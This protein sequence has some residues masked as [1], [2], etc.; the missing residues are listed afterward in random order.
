MIIVLG[1]VVARPGREQA[2]RDVSLAHVRRSQI[3]PGCL[4][5]NVSVD[6]ENPARF[7]F[8]EHWQ[9]MPALMTHFAR[10]ESQSFVRDLQPL[11]SET[12]IMKIFR[13][14]EVQPKSPG[15]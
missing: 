11:L 7:V 5:H 9:D 3:E 1:S 6:C 10:D 15:E 13:A 4:A 12:P 8:V 14:D 2:V